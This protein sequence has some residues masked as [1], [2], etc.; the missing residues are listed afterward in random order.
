MFATKISEGLYRVVY[1]ANK[2]KLIYTIRATD[3]FDAIMQ[4]LTYLTLEVSVS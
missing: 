2:L 4:M 1:G 3:S